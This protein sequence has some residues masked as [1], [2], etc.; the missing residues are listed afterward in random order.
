M[1][2]NV[3]QSSSSQVLRPESAPSDRLP[4][5]LSTNWDLPSGSPEGLHALSDPGFTCLGGCLSCFAQFFLKSNPVIHYYSRAR[6]KNQRLNNFHPHYYRDNNSSTPN[7]NLPRGFNLRNFDSA[8]LFASQTVTHSCR[9]CRHPVSQ[10]YKPLLAMNI[11]RGLHIYHIILGHIND[12]KFVDIFGLDDFFKSRDFFIY[13]LGPR[14]GRCQWRTNNCSEAMGH[15]LIDVVEF[16]CQAE[17]P[18]SWYLLKS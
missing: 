10:G 4:C 3:G 2:R 5:S 11:K 8:R 17:P 18:R 12:F 1:G 9:L 6:E 14:W 7:L 13:I 16:C 15:I